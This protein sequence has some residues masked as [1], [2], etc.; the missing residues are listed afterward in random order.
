MEFSRNNHAKF[1]PDQIWN[2]G[3]FD[4]LVAVTP[5]KNNKTKN[6]KNNMSS[7]MGSATWSKNGVSQS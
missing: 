6:Q 1:Y 5:N 2:N 4:I 7:D 3:A